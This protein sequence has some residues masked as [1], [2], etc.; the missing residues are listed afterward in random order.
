M[1]KQEYLLTCLMEEL[2]ETALE[3]LRIH[4]PHVNSQFLE[5][6]GH[7]SKDPCGFVAV[8]DICNPVVPFLK[9]EQFEPVVNELI[10]I[11]GAWHCLCVDGLMAQN[12][13]EYGLPFYIGRVTMRNTVPKSDY[14]YSDLALFLLDASK[15]CSKLL[16]FGIYHNHPVTNGCAKDILEEIMSSFEPFV[17]EF[18]IRLG[19][20]IEEIRNKRDEKCIK[21]HHY[22]KQSMEN[23]IVTE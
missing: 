5:I 21:I 23:G 2:S 11:L 19:Y 20:S 9:S 17:S 7:S 8:A 12:Y 1:N 18:L 4:V 6:K 14:H 15:R 3:L 13:R 16:R 22:L 10:D